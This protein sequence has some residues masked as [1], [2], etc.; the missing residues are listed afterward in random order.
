MDEEVVTELIQDECNSKNIR[1]ELKK[2]LEP[3]NRNEL[4]KKYDILESKLGGIGAS[5][6]TAQLIVRNLK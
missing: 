1:I 4:L 5:K 6:K 3:N 2:I